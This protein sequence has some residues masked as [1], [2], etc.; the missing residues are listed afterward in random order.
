[1]SIQF[2]VQIPYLEDIHYKCH[3]KVFH[4]NTKYINYT[5][6]HY[7]K[8]IN[9]GIQFLILINFQLKPIHFLHL[10]LQILLY[11]NLIF[12]KIKLIVLISAQQESQMIEKFSNELGVQYQNEIISAPNQN[13]IYPFYQVPYRINS[14]DM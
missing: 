4:K 3:P 6:C 13:Q 7:I 11:L 2:Q 8:C 1:M 10:I 12:C 9:N 5:L 14:N